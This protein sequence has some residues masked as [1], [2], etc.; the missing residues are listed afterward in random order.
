MSEYHIEAASPNANGNTNQDQ[1]I[2]HESPDSVA[3]RALVAINYFRDIN[4]VLHYDKNPLLKDY[5]FHDIDFIVEIFKSVFHHDITQVIDYQSDE[6][7]QTRFKELE[8]E[9]AVK[10]Y[11]NEGLLCK[12]LLG[13]F[14]E[15][16]NLSGT[17]EG[18][19]IEFMRS[20]NLCFNI[21]QDNDLLYFPWFVKAQKCPEYLEKD[22]LMLFDKEHASVQLQCEF[23]NM[24]PLNVFEMVCVCLQRKATKESHYMGDRQAWKDGLVV[25]FGS[26]ECVVN[27]STK[28]SCI[29]IY[30]R[31]K[32]QDAP[33]IWSI[34]DGLFKEISSILSEWYGV[35]KS[36][37]IICGHCVIEG[38]VPPKCWHPDYVFPK[39]GTL[40]QPRV[41]CSKDSRS[42][43]P[44]SLVVSA[45][46]GITVCHYW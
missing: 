36:I 25:S 46:K 33:Q 6:K 16:Y 12:K 45:F 26:V 8:C 40:V 9:T 30:V 37:H 2:S 34:V 23:F 32:I 17:D 35:I 28:T 18:V 11:Q 44:A 42:S 39:A 3:S 38:I 15:Q 20:F 13:Y 4:L 14:W 10:R 21:S 29:N 22:C 5:V 7:L 19:F 24:I 1:S 41:S 31:G 27:R 43:L